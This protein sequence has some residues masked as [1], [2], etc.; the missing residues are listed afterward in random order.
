[1]P[2]RPSSED[3]S[4]EAD[5]EQDLSDEVGEDEDGEIGDLSTLPTE[6][7]SDQ[8][9]DADADTGAE[10]DDPGVAVDDEPFGKDV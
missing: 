10:D 8:D 5:P 3:W 6:D 9:E 1:M 7:G 2:V 4:A